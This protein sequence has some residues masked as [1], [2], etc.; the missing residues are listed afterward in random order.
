MFLLFKGQHF[1]VGIIYKLFCLQLDNYWW[2]GLAAATTERAPA[3]GAPS[4]G[5]ATTMAARGATA[6]ASGGTANA[7]VHSQILSTIPML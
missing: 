1:S 6:T 5:A 4:T 3:L 2:S 7:S